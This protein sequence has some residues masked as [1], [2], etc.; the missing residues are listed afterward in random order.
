MNLY[1]AYGSNLSRAVRVA[2]GLEGMEFA[3]RAWLPDHQLRFRRRTSRGSGALD[4]MPAKGF[5]V[6]GALFRCSRVHRDLLDEKEG[7]QTGM[8]GNAY[9]R[10]EVAVLDPCGGT[11]QAF[12][13]RVVDPDRFV[14]PDAGY[15]ARVASGY[16]EL[17][18][19]GAEYLS[20]AAA[21]EPAPNHVAGCFVYGTLRCGGELHQFVRQWVLQRHQARTRG[22]LVDLGWFPGFVAPRRGERRTV[23]GELLEARDLLQLLEVTDDLEGFRGFDVGYSLGQYRRALVRLRRPPDHPLAWIYVCT[24]AGGHP[25]IAHGDWMRWNRERRTRPTALP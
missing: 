8:V 7:Y 3:R 10:V 16:R 22:T 9:A 13:Y 20:S 15:L 23:T 25:E 17:G 18:V 5:V 2:S 14:R 21:N 6:P 1:F 19:L 12:T 11:V 24:R 4:V